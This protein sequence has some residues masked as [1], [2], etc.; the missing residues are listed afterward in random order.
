MN[1]VYKLLLWFAMLSKRLYKK[2]TFLALMVLIPVL[3]LGYVALSSGESGVV[4]IGL[5]CEEADPITENIFTELQDGSQLLSF[6]ICTDPQEAESLLRGGKLDAVWIFSGNM[7]ERIEQFAKQPTSANGFIKVMERE[8]SV[9][10]MLSRER[11]NGAVYPYV[12]QRVYVHFLRNLAP[13]LS[14]LS[15]EQ[16]MEYYWGTNLSFELFDFGDVANQQKQTSF[17]VFPLRGLLGIL[18]LLCALATGMYYIQDMENG[19]FSWVSRHRQFLPE[20]GCQIVSTLHIATV[21]LI[22]LAC[23]GLAGTWW[24]ELLVL[25]IY[26]LCCSVFAMAMRQLCGS[27]NLLGAMLPLVIVVSLVICPV[28]FDL[29]AMRRLQYLLPPTYYVNSIYNV[30]YLLYMAEYIATVSGLT[31]L[32]QYVKYR[33]RKH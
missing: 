11:L 10:L 22:C 30:R 16:L 26:S 28:F 13:E 2:P 8:D 25:V 3:V 12:T 15:D 9:A 17:L 19:T 32:V 33:V 29:G 1:K 7:E 20:L 14:H 23:C 5:A 21:C 4:T 31:V 27:V 18:I 6:R 24:K